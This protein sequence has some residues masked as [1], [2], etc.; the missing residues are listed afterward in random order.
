MQAVRYEGK[1]YKI[2]PKSYEPER[3][4]FEIAW[5]LIREPLV[6]KEE[7]YRRWFKIEQ[8]NVK[9]LYPSFRKD[10]PK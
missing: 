10:E 5:H 8:E 6:A 2:V 9:V 4:T 3:Q 7:A 1:W